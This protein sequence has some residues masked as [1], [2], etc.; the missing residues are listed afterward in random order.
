[1][2]ETTRRSLLE[3]RTPDALSFSVA[4]ALVDDL[5]SIVVSPLPLWDKDRF[6]TVALRSETLEL[7]KRNASGVELVRL[8]RLLLEDAYPQGLAKAATDRPIIIGVLG[9]DPF[10]PVLDQTIRA[11]KG[12]RSLEVRRVASL[13]QAR[14]CQVVFIGKSNARYEA[15]WLDGLK[16]QPILTVGESGET[17][18]RGGVVEFVVKNNR[19]RFEVSWP[20][21]QKAG[22]KISALMLNSASKVHGAPDLNP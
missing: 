8:H 1:L 18:G 6:A 9:S 7:T 19:V 12:T 14:E 4:Q 15:D 10:G 21:M 2:R 5:N 16:D 13:Q 17:I 3:W 20:A 22:L 11:Q